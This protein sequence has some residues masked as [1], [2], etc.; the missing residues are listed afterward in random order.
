MPCPTAI[1]PNST[2]QMPQWVRIC[3][4][5]GIYWLPGSVWKSY[6][7]HQHAVQAVGWK[8]IGFNPKEHDFPAFR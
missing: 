7:Y 3:P 5:I 2:I 4:G 8:P 1:S 6:P